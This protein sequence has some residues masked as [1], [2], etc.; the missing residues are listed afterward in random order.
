VDET[1]ASVPFYVEGYSG[2]VSRAL[3][4]AFVARG[5][6]SLG[7]R[8]YFVV[9]AEKPEEFAAAS[10]LKPDVADPLKLRRVFGSDEFETEFYR[11]SIDRATGG[12]T[13]FDK[14]LNRVVTA[15]GG[16]VAAEQRGG[17]TLSIERPSGRTVVHSISRVE[18]EQNNAVRAVVRIEGEVGGVPVTQRVTLYGGLKKID[19]ENTVECRQNH[20]LKLEQVF[21][22]EDA[23]AKIRYGVP[24]GSAGNEDILPNSGPHFSDEV[25]RDIWKQ[26]RQIQDWVWVGG[27]AGG[28]TVSADRQLV[29]LEERAVRVGMMRG[30]YSPVDVVRDGKPYLHQFPPAGRYVFHYSLTSGKGDWAA[31]KS[32][33][34]GM[35]FSDPLLPVAA[36]NE[37]STKSLLPTYS[38]LSQGSENVVVTA[39]KKAEADDSLV[40]R[41]V[42]MEG[43]ATEAAIQAMGEP[44]R[45]TPVD[46][47]EEPAGQG[48]VERLRLA[49]YE[50]GT[51]KLDIRRK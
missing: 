33:R 27:A 7:Y 17:D 5:V 3:E 37:I 32:Y 11:V 38:F 44:R 15:G 49:P 16:V 51:V 30:A 31:S 12:V 4:I 48:T 42:E 28:F 29:T 26:W 34:S 24:F 18:L 39:L 13:V 6:P 10:K 23:A 9:P 21:P 45:L 14:E 8:T 19:I 36:E 25:P 22:Y 20:F 2:T 35:E 41:V 1:G 46:M 43:K 40:L 50:I 47:L